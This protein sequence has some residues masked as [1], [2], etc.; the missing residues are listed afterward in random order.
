MLLSFSDNQDSDDAIEEPE[1]IENLVK[2]MGLDLHPEQ[3][4]EREFRCS[5]KLNQ[6]QSCST[7]FMVDE[8]QNV[9]LGFME[10]TREELD[11]AILAKLSCGMHLSALTSRSRKKAQ[12]ERK[13][14]RTDFYFHGSR[15]CRDT[16]KFI[17][18]I[19]QDKLTNLIKHYKEK[20]VQPRVHK[21]SKR[22]P[23]NALKLEETRAAV[24]FILNY[25]EANCNILPGRAPRHWRTDL[26]L[27]PS[28]CSKRKVYDQYCSAVENVGMRKVALRTFRHLWAK[29]VP[30]VSTMRP[31]TDLCWFCQKNLYKITRSANLHDEEKTAT[32]REAEAHL[33]RAMME[34]SLYQTITKQVALDLRAGSV[35]GPHPVCSYE[36]VMHYSF[37]FAQQVHYPGNPLQPG[38]IFF[39][40]PR[41]CGLFGVCCGAF[42]KQVNYLF[43]ECVQTGKGANCVISLIHHFFEFYGLG[44]TDLH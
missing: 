6:G 34:R 18:N 35:L 1:L 22:R 36:G 25:A 39:K 37:D 5:C 4:E 9:R 33:E 15:I 42:P 20:G 8:L 16:F 40:T 12:T 30:F 24:D 17:H 28:S 19:S 11:V 26:K 14:Q 27:L 31:A 32:I 21:N 7:Q 10:L 2:G 13:A 44:E 41:K 38:P 23:P 3:H 43:D 29:L